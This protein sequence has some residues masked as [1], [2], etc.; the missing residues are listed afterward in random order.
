LGILPVKDAFRKS[1]SNSMDHKI[2]QIK[3]GDILENI[4][5]LPLEP[6][7]IA[8][9]SAFFTGGALHIASTRYD[10]DLAFDFNM[11]PSPQEA[12]TQ[13]YHYQLQKGYYYQPIEH[14]SFPKH[15]KVDGWQTKHSLVLAVAWKDTLAVDGKDKVYIAHTWLDGRISVARSE[16]EG[17]TFSNHNRIDGWKTK[18]SPALAV[19][20]NGKVYIAYTWLDGSIS[21]ARSEDE[22]QTFPHHNKINGWQTNYSPALAVGENGKVYIA[23]TWLDG[24]I[25]IARSED[26]GK[27][28]PNHNKIKVWKTKHSPAL[29]V[30]GNGKVYIAHTWLDRSISIARSEDDWLDGSI[31]IARSEDEGKIFPNH[32]KID[33]W[34]TKHSPALAVDGNGKVYVAYVWFDGSISVAESED[35]GKTFP[36]YKRIDGW[37]T[38]H[39]PALAVNGNGKIHIAHTWLKESISVA[40]SNNP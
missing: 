15:K 7:K 37:K 34:T 3:G 24:S 10:K 31:S 12:I 2:A 14:I 18:H 11:V 32:N 4:I 6:V 9:K 26:E 27:T 33:G 35:E 36:N 30:G 40:V 21:V 28:F 5:D 23:H 22:G 38:E 1:L 19:G 29:A 25:S 20:G 17:Q 13:G 8:V 16:D 39:S